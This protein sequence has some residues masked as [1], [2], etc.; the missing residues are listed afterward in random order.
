[1]CFLPCK[2][3]RGS[4][5][6]SGEDMRS[7]FSCNNKYAAAAAAT[8]ITL[9]TIV[10]VFV[11]DENRLFRYFIYFAGLFCCILT[12]LIGTVTVEDNRLILH[13]AYS[14]KEIH[15]SDI[16]ECVCSSDYRQTRFEG[17]YRIIMTVTTVDGKHIMIWDKLTVEA[18]DLI[19]SPNA[20]KSEIADHPFTA[21]C[22]YIDRYIR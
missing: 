17:Y 21:M 1:M 8:L 13:Y 16:K 9:G 12:E 7:D 11:P 19:K 4:D 5:V 6:C 18:S 22:R 14:K 3:L 15:L 10:I 2:L 20:L